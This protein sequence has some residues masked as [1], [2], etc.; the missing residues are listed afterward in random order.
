MGKTNS[1]TEDA[2]SAISEV[3]EKRRKYGGVTQDKKW[4]AVQH[5]QISEEIQL[6]MDNFPLYVSIVRQWLTG[7]ELASVISGKLDLKEQR[8]MKNWKQ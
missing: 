1:W 8:I 3:R 4:D 7:K 5:F 2:K 6:R